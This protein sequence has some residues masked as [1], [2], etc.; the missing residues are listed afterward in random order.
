MSKVKYFATYHGP[1]YGSYGME[2]VDGYR[3]LKEAIHSMRNR[4]AGLDY[5][6]E[7]RENEDGSMV[8]WYTERRSEFPGATGGDYMD[9]YAAFPQGDGTYSY[10]DHPDYRLTVGPRGGIVVERG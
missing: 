4:Q 8:L 7:Y 1:L 10:A 5:S 9:L 6:D 3:S 2:Y